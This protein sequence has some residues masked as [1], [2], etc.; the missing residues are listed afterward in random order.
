MRM[1]ASRVEL[2]GGV[3]V[4]LSRR[5]NVVVVFVVFVVVECA[6][7]SHHRA[8]LAR[9]DARSHAIANPPSFLSNSFSV[10]ST[11]WD[12]PRMDS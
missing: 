2:V 12:S 9:R 3:D 6:E 7:L 1:D 8:R 4:V 11:S 10:R 5:P